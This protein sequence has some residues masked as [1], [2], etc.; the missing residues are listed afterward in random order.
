MR[1]AIMQPYYFPYI[2]YFELAARVDI[3]VFY[4]DAAFSKNSWFN[5]NRILARQKDFEYIRVSV[6]NAPLG[7]PSRQ[8]GLMDKSSDLRRS[9]GILDVYRT[10]PFF[11]D[12]SALLQSVFQDSGEDLASIAE[13]S[14]TRCCERLAIAP[15]FLR[16]STLDYD[17]SLGAVG[18]VLDIC[19]AAGAT[20]Y[21]NLSGGTDLYDQ[22][23]FARHGLKLTFTQPSALVYA[24][25]LPFVGNLSILD[26]LM[27]LPVETIK[28][29]LQSRQG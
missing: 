18:K 28:T 11:R 27:R 29:Y 9:L 15:K 25:H 5:R 24:D 3:F 10:A 1:V 7:T 20:E 4:D 23:T 22:E 13:L 17:R 26:P 6:A 19:R 21:V 12:V 16:S 14:V 8:V 2:G